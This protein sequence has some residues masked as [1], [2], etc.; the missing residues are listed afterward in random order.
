M[1]RKQTTGWTKNYLT[2][3]RDTEKLNISLKTE[4]KTG[5]VYFD[6]SK[7]TRFLGGPNRPKICVGRTKPDLK[8]W[9]HTIHSGAVT[10]FFN[11]WC[12][13]VEIKEHLK[14]VRYSITQDTHSINCN[15]LKQCFLP[16][17]PLLF[18]CFPAFLFFLRDFLGF[19]SFNGD[20]CES[21][22]KG[23]VTLI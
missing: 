3:R 10:A 8:D 2:N 20:R 7:F 16:A 1:L 13:R 18:Q 4:T 19:P 21:P 6:L 22:D 17:N 14:G 23:S 9:A 5:I 11:C 15:L 12:C